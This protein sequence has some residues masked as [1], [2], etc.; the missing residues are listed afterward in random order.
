MP[1]P[2]YVLG[3]DC[4][5]Q[6]LRA[7]VFDLQG[8]PVVFASREYPVYYPKVGWAE[9]EPQDWWNAA[10]ECVQECLREGQLR[11]EDIVGLSVDGTSCTM[12]PVRADGTPLRRA[13]LWM[14]V[15]AVSQAERVTKTKH[16]VLKYVSWVE[17]PE[18]MIPKSLWIKEN[19]PDIYEQ[20][21]YLIECTDWMMFQLT[22]RWA[23]SLNNATCKWNYAT[24]EGGWPADLLK[25]LNFTDVLEKWPQDVIAMGERV[26]TLSPKAAEEL[27]LSPRTVVAQGGIDA[28]AAMLGLRVVEPGQMALVMGS[29]T[30]HLALSACGIFE[31]HVWGPY[32]DALIRGTWVL[33]GGQTT[34]G[35]IVKWFRDHFCAREEEEARQ[36][37]VEVYE[38]LDEKA[39]QVPPGAEGLVLLDYFQGNR[40]PLRDPLARGTMVGLGLKHGVGHIFR[41]IYEGT[42][43]GTRH[44]L[45]DLAAAGFRPTG[46]YACG[47]GARSALWLQIHADVCKVPLYLT[48]VPDATVFGT[49]ICAA[50]AAGCYHSVQEAAR[51]M[52]HITRSIEPNPENRE[53]YDFYFKKYVEMYPALRQTMHDL[54][55]WAG[56]S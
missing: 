16:P 39:A 3:I 15:R 33:E 44:I 50:A 45:E 52:V 27:G 1:K 55:H 13:L 37:G 51:Q 26:G 4:G 43:Y 14:D 11:P 2:P 49:A 22:G 17:S 20:A 54:A 25:Q 31:S 24:P 30:C 21:D 47:G 41:A 12:L 23:A 5:T 40:T 53:V 34:T 8:E 38:V 48:K 19:E 18:W 46:I 29:S 56:G 28:Y 9:Q 32:P 42:A 6:S 7:G 10:R 36:R 35:A